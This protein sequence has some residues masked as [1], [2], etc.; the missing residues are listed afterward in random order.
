MFK[1]TI[2]VEI[3][4]GPYPTKKRCKIDGAKVII[5]EGSKGRGGEAIT[6]T[7]DNTCLIPFW[8]GIFPFRHIKYKLH[9]IEGTS[10]CVSYSPTE[11]GK[12]PKVTVAQVSKYA[13]AT[14]IKQAGSLKPPFSL[15]LIYVFLIGILLI[16]IIGLLVSTGN[17]RF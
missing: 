9:Y 16:S 3:F 13:E 4:G 1:P 5:K 17:L 10:K 12:T 15:G 2:R 7:F 11:A 8:S 14:V 6:A